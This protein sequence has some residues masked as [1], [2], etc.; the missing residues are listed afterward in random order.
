MSRT[1]RLEVIGSDSPLVGLRRRRLGFAEVLAQSVA[2]VAPSAA[3]VTLPGIV[4]GL[5]GGAAV[6]A[7]LVAGLVVILVGLCVTV[8]A[9]RMASASG[10]VACTSCG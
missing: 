6:V 3:A 5:A 2:A 4:I 1:H 9:R 8:F 10:P 7:F